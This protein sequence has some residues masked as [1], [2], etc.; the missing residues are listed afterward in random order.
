MTDTLC[1]APH[2]RDPDR[3]RLA[4]DG[5]RVCH[6]HRTQLYVRLHVL[7]AAHEAL[8]GKLQAGGEGQE[9]VGG[10]PSI[11]LDLDPRAVRCRSEVYSFL[12]SWCRYVAHQR[13]ARPPTDTCAAMGPWL[14]RQLDWLCA[15]PADDIGDLYGGLNAHYAT[16]KHLLRPDG[17]KHRP[18]GRCVEMTWCDVTSRTEY[19]CDGTLTA[20][21]G[22]ADDLLPPAMVCD[23]CQVVVPASQWYTFGRKYQAMEGAA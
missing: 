6:G 16:A 10:T 12:A 3:P 8:A 17:R 2:T 18:V 20:F 9:H 4:L 7:G 19:R 15:L 11:G 23:T 14:A 13:N 5:L 1:A 21:L 22:P